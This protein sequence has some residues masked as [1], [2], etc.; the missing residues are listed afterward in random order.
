MSQSTVNL[1]QQQGYEGTFIT[2]ESVSIRGALR[3]YLNNTTDIIPFGR[4]LILAS[5]STT[6]IQLPSGSGNT[7]IGVSVFNDFQKGFYISNP[8][9]QGYA[10]GAN[11]EVLIKGIGDVMVWSNTATNIDD[12]VYVR[13]QNGVAGY[14]GVAG[15]GTF[16]NSA[17]ADYLLW[18]GA[19][20]VTPTSGAG[21]AVINIGGF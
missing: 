9:S 12:P 20:F 5:G 3:P 11:V 1:F 10:I 18:N 16:R 8:L 15:L 21:L 7:I 14:Q 17:N 4:A 6:N 13:Y 19:R 2:K